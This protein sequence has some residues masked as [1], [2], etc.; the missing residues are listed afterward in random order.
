MKE[1]ERRAGSPSHEEEEEEENQEPLTPALSPQG[2]E[3]VERYRR[4]LN[5]PEIPTLRRLSVG[6]WLVEKPD[7]VELEVGPARS[8]LKPGPSLTLRALLRGE[9]LRDGLEDCPTRGRRERSG[10]G[11]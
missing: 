2:G 8:C 11:A 1:I 7:P 3:R 4:A 10:I 9:R 6:V 5:P